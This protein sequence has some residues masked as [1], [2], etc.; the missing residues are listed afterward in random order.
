MM[1]QTIEIE[2][3][4]LQMFKLGQVEFQCDVYEFLLKLSE[5]KN[6]P[7]SHSD[8]WKMVREFIMAAGGPSCSYAEA[9]AFVKAVTAIGD[10]IKKKLGP[11]PSSPEN[12]ASTV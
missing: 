6:A 3:M 9:M 8:Y 1:A 4:G 11:E 5:L 7:S 2:T 10:E 12:T